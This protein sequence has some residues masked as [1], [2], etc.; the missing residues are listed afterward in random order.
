[1]ADIEQAPRY[2]AKQERGD[3]DCQAGFRALKRQ[4]RMGEHQ[5][6]CRQERQKDEIPDQGRTGMAPDMYG[7]VMA[8]GIVAESD[9]ALLTPSSQVS[10]RDG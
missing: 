8:F 10:D 4:H 3:P 6:R 9:Q 7:S 2:A 5:E 1:M